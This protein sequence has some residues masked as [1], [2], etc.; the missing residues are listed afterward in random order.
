MGRF[1]TVRR[2]FTYLHVT[3][4]KCLAGTIYYRCIEPMLVLAKSLEAC[5]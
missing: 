1:E 5:N 2:D 3:L 4:A